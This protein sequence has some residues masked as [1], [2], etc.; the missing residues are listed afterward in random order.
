[1]PD[2]GSQ[3]IHYE[4]FHELFGGGMNSL[5]FREIREKQGLCYNIGT[6]DWL[7]NGHSGVGI[8][9]SGIDYGKIN[10]FCDAVEGVKQD[11]INNG[12]DQVDFLAGKNSILGQFCRA[13]QNPE[14][15]AMDIANYELFGVDF[16]FQVE[17]D[18]CRNVEFDAVNEYAKDFLLNMKSNWAIMSPTTEG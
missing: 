7:S 15:M 4:M 14:S 17:Y 6:G 9:S 12:F 10:Q 11:I 3:N 5:L 8:L 16:D 18:A 2:I 1:M 13:M